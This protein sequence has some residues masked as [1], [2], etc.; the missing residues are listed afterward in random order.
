MTGHSRLIFICLL[1][2]GGCSSSEKNPEF[3]NHSIQAHVLR[4]TKKGA[5][6]ENIRNLSLPPNFKINVFARP[7]GGPRM[8]ALAAN[9]SVYVTRRD[10]GDVI[11]LWDQNGDG[12]SDFQKTAVTL[13]SV[14]GIA[15]QNNDVFLTTVTEVYRTS[16]QKGGEFGKLEVL[17]SKLPEGGA[18]SQP[19]DCDGAGGQPLCFSGE[20]LQLLP[21]NKPPNCHPFENE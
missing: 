5:T 14:H 13:K 15:I 9:G 21:R 10:H 2:I 6:P 11:Q 8:M 17:D 19:D 12:V 20:Y 18:T 4:P 3:V 7:L 1:G 16:I